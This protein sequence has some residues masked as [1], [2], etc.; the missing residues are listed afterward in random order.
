MDE[1]VH[2]PAG[3]DGKP[4]ARAAY[5][6]GFSDGHRLA[7]QRHLAKLRELAALQPPP[8]YI[9]APRPEHRKGLRTPWS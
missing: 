6:Q 4:M 7:E 8:Q 2:I 5:L 9:L 3:L 1:K